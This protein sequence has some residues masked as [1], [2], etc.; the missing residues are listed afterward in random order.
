MSMRLRGR[1]LG[2]L[3]VGS[4]S[5]WP[6][7]GVGQEVVCGPGGMTLRGWE[8]RARTII[9]DREGSFDGRFSERGILQRFHPLMD[10]EYHL[11]VISSSF[12]LDEECAWYGRDSGARFWAGSID[13]LRL[14][15][16]GQIKTRVP[17]GSH[18]GVRVEHLHEETLRA[19]RNLLRLG[20]ER[21]LGDGAVRLFLTG[22]PIAI[23]PQSDIEL[24]ASWFPGEGEVTVAVGALDVFSDVV[25]QVLGVGAALADST[26]DYLSRP[27][28]VRVFTELPLHRDLRMEGFG[29]VL[30]STRVRVEPQG[31]PWGGFVQ[32]EGY[33]YAGGLVEW[34]PGDRTAVGGIATWKRGRTERRP[35]EGN[36]LATT[37]FLDVLET[38]RQVGAFFLHDPSP[39]L[40]IRG[41]LTRVTE[42]EMRESMPI[43]SS[44][45]KRT[46]LMRLDLTY[47]GGSGFHGE[48]GLDSTARS[49]DG[50]RPVSPI[51]PLLRS[52]YRL[53]G[54]VGWRFG[55][56]ALF[57]L[58]ANLDLDSG[59]FDG[60]HGR[61]S[62]SW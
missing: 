22:T 23:K 24:G 35:V 11:D 6:G 9:L 55:E 26:L 14:I 20:F 47:R 49:G 32:K 5:A 8:E 3:L 58:G 31:E 7:A 39:R 27:Y 37:N 40:R 54:D 44:Y 43:P 60:G 1:L 46:L 15:Q 51:Q 50:I 16:L 17:L 52:D 42:E 38:S 33:A 62:L 19:R 13:H 59:G 45:H 29:L 48:L 28:T 57:V 4:V 41:W 53:R 34:T 18:W 12:P 2:T 25:Y 10:A 21:D 56:G 36:V 61:F 30:T